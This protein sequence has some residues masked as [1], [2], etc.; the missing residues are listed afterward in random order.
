MLKDRD[1]LRARFQKV[2][3]A[4][5]KNR[6]TKA[7]DEALEAELDELKQTRDGIHEM[8]KQINSK[9]TLNFF[10][11]E[12][13]LPN[14]AFPE[15]GIE[16]KSIIL[17]KREKPTPDE[18]KFQAV[19][20]EYIRPANS[21]ITELAPGS[22][23]YAGGR[24][25]KVDQIGMGVSPVETWHFCDT[26]GHM[27]RISAD[28]PAKSECP[29][30]GSPNWADASLKRE[31]IRLRQVV[32]TTIDSKSRSHDDSDQRE[33]QF[34]N[35]HESVVIPEDS[36]RIAYQIR[37]ASVPFGF[38][39][40]AKLVLRVVNLGQD[41]QS[42]HPF[43]LGGR[44]VCGSGFVLCAE[45]GKIQTKRAGS[46]EVEM[47]HDLSC[48]FHGKDSTPLKAVFLYR[49]LHS[50]AIRIL[51]PSSG[52]TEDTDMTSFVAALHLGLRLYF[53]GNIDHLKGCVDE[54]PVS[55]TNLRR[56]YLVLYDQVPGGTGYLKQLSRSP[57]A[58]MDVLR[59]AL[60]H[61][62]EC[63]CETRDDHDTDGCHRCI[64]QARHRRDHAGLSRRR[65]IAL[66][67]AILESADQVEQVSRVSDIDIHPLIKSQLEKDFLESLRAVLG[68]QLQAKIVRGKPGYLWRSG[69]TAWEIAPQVG[70][71]AGVE[72]DVPSI[73]DYVLYPVR[74][75]VSRPIAVFLDG[76][77]FHADERS[78]RNRVARDMEQRQSL[79]KSGKFWVWN[80][81]WEDIQYRNDPSKIPATP[82]GESHV[83][84]RNGIAHQFLS[85][86]D[87]A[88]AESAAVYSSWTLFLEYLQ[89]PDAKRWR[90]LSY[91]YALAL[92]AKLAR[93][94][95]EAAGDA[96]KVLLQNTGVLPALQEEPTGDGVGAAF[97]D[98]Q[99][100]GLTISAIDGVASRNP[101]RLFFLLHFNDDT[102]LLDAEFP[103]HWRGFLRLINRLQFLS[104]SHFITTRGVAGGAF[105]GI[106][107]EYLHFTAGG[108]APVR[109]ESSSR[110]VDE[111]RL[112]DLEL[113]APSLVSFFTELITMSLSWP[114]IGYEHEERG[115]IVATVEAAW[116]DRKIAI[117]DE[118]AVA[119]L[120][121]F[122]SAGWNV[123]LFNAA[124]IIL[125]Q[126]TELLAL[127]SLKS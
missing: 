19:T 78:G 53:R 32:S 92:P 43:R 3:R 48:R 87:L 98:H 124:G 34:F 69:E 109:S 113:V 66:L 42:T 101:D 110:H 126:R 62:V 117:L 121:V 112:A 21:A 4:I 27:E 45:C 85:G 20:Y 9:L 108:S 99:I 24:R 70:V 30:C 6:D 59:F 18:G 104:N 11:D 54:R 73:P 12:G 95:L 74:F 67:K 80:F 46:G 83:S 105:A 61:L 94:G 79:L 1:D 52:A 56:K 82:L 71:P 31:L 125:E 7:R 86:D 111:S 89:R 40:L 25:L 15:E 68:S 35:R 84:L 16:L 115:I 37:G 39:F 97:S 2:G 14:Y 8:L 65:A 63:E 116:T 17:K 93:I 44:E 23:F 10:T 38:E 100:A 58:F 60:K 72:S 122:R 77:T 123:F 33:Q 91:L 28:T 5:R 96:V 64:L 90:Q 118:A 103:R 22:V 114:E 120:N 107:D 51:L 81:S 26:C 47:R 88:L 119:D 127:L 29:A 102:G 36:E 13:L 50:E 41:D 75:E 57:G 55:G 106:Y 76:F 49:E